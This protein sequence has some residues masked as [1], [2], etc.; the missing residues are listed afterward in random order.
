MPY[1]LPRPNSYDTGPQLLFNRAYDQCLDLESRQTQVLQSGKLGVLV[2][3]RFLGYMILEAP[4]DDGR[5]EFTTEI[6]RCRSDDDLQKLADIYK[7][8][9][10]RVC[11]SRTAQRATPS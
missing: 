7:D 1:P 10:L 3:A 4:T 8:H 6:L 11:K 2:C 5:K 9:F